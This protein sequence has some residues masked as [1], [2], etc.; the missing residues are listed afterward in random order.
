MK[1]TKLALKQF[2]KEEITSSLKEQEPI[3]PEVATV[4]DMIE[5]HMELV[6]ELAKK[7][8]VEKEL[9]LAAVTGLI[10]IDYGEDTTELD[11]HA[12]LETIQEELDLLKR[13]ESATADVFKHGK[14]PVDVA[15][16]YTQD[17]NDEDKKLFLHWF[18]KNL[19]LWHRRGGSTGETPENPGI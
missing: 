4:M 9:L 18:D 12:Q 3:P 5:G 2:I 16:E 6:T 13:L 17:M 7:N 10:N 11:P 8:G 15:N 1:L 14:S 19:D